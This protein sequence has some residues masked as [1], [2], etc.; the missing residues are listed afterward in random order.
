MV[1]EAFP[2]YF[3]FYETLR[4]MLPIF[5]P[6]DAMNGHPPIVHVIFVPRFET[7]PYWYVCMPLLPPFSEENIQNFIRNKL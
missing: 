2:R 3:N 7:N 4:L 5:H 6:G 1:M